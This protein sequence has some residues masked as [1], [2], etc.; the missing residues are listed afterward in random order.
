[1]LQ[2]SLFRHV[3][4]S[5]GSTVVTKKI[6]VDERRHILFQI[7]AGKPHSASLME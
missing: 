1:M 2:V 5:S 3:S 4:E 6:R 7:E